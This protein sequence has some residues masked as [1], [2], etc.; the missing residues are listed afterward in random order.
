VKEAARSGK[1]L[2]SYKEEAIPTRWIPDKARRYLYEKDEHNRKRLLPDR[3]EFLLY[4]HLRQGIEAGDIFCRGS[5]RFRSIKDDLL[6]DQRWADKEKLVAEAGLEILQQPIET[7][8]AALK[9]LLETRITEV[10]RR[11][12]TGENEH[13]S[14]GVVNLSV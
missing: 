2:G 5:V 12:S 7:H 14:V 6:S 4:R 1:A 8:L 9:D 3:Y 11:V 10:N 13:F